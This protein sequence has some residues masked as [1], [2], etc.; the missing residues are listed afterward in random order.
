MTLSDIAAKYLR[1]KKTS[2]IQRK[3][4]TAENLKGNGEIDSGH[5]AD[6]ILSDP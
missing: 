5:I 3:I 4:K 6:K 1:P 2:E